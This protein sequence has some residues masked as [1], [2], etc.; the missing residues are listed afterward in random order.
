MGGWTD[1]SVR[2]DP[3]NPH[4]LREHLAT[5]VVLGY[6]TVAA[7]T[8]VTAGDKSCGRDITRGLDPL[9][10]KELESAV[11]ADASAQGARPALALLTR[12]TIRFGEPGELQT[13]LKTHDESVRR[14][15][16]LALEP[17]SERALASA[18]ASRR[19]DLIAL[20]LGA[21]MPFR[22]RAG[23][24]KAASANGIAFEVAYNPALMETTS[25]RNFFANA[26]AV[27]R[28]CGGGG[29]AGAKDGTGGVVVITGASRQA[30]ELRGPHDVVNLAT[31]FGMKDGDARR[32]LSAR[33]DA[34]VA[35]ARRRK[36]SEADAN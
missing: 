35:R 30:T 33:C 10:T 13:L 3:D 31:M 12:L 17:T 1:L 14:Y 20:Q 4:A 9:L 36:A 32:A 26:S 22:L 27:A 15:D 5:S 7:D 29:D 8:R 18:C 2:A 6:A 19:C 25:R 21:R 23:A 24:V 11:L 16:V 28:A 34:V